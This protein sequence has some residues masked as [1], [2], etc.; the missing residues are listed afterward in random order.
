MPDQERTHVAKTARERFM[1]AA[2]EQM[3][4]FERQEAQ[5]SREQ[6]A[7]QLNL[8]AILNKPLH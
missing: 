5:I 7:V 2:R 8:T 4:L 1:E 3:V 6:R